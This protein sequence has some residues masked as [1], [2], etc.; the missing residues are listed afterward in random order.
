MGI[1]VD[2]TLNSSIQIFSDE[3]EVTSSLFDTKPR[4]PELRS[5]SMEQ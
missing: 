3:E 1:L 5:C 2:D 4:L